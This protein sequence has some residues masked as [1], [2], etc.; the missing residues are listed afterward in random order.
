MTQKTTNSKAVENNTR[1]IQEIRQHANQE[2]SR[3][4]KEICT[5]KK[6]FEK[7]RGWV[8]QTKEMPYIFTVYLYRHKSS[9]HL[10]HIQQV[11]CQGTICMVWSLTQLL[12]RDHFSAPLHLLYVSFNFPHSFPHHFLPSLRDIYPLLDVLVFTYA[13]IPL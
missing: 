9:E 1:H 5:V 11:D 2:E 6:S 10:S 3:D 12:S 7:V 13:C 8:R 4:D